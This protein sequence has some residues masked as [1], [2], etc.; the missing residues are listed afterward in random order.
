[1]TGRSGYLRFKRLADCTAGAALLIA[2]LPVLVAAALAIKA[3]SPGSVLFRQ[4]RVGLDGAEFE[5]LKLRTMTHEASD[6]LHR[7]F[8]LDFL[9]DQPGR[10]RHP[11]VV[12]D[13]KAHTDPPPAAGESGVQDTGSR[14]PFKIAA[15]P[16]ITRVGKVLR[17]WS[18]DEI[19]QLLN[20]IRGDMSLIGPR[21]DLPYHRGRLSVK[22]GLTGLWQVSGRGMLSPTDMLRLD[23]EYAEQQSFW[24]D[25][26]ILAKTIPAILHKVGAE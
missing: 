26:K 17:R 9:T 2:S 8:V 5:V 12:P 16:R 15:D 22:P 13:V 24:L 7:Q 3:S 25:L 11:A 14:T 4:K 23:V 21:P 6:D 20:V 18:V 10:Q 19:P 1:M